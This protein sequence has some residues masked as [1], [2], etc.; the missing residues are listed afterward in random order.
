[1]AYTGDTEWTDQL[2]PA[3]AGVDLFVAEAY[4]FDKKVK[5]HLDLVSLEEQLPRIQPKRLVIT[6]MSDDMLGRVDSLPY[7]S[8]Y[9]GKVVEL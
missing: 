9:D 5:L 1:M 8:A 7:E 3:A 6:H 4:F 2:I